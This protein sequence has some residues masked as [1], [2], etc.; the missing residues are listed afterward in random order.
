M[1]VSIELDFTATSLPIHLLEIK[2]SLD[3]ELGCRRT[4]FSLDVTKLCDG[5]KIFNLLDVK[6]NLDPPVVRGKQTLLLWSNQATSLTEDLIETGNDQEILILI[7]LLRF[8]SWIQ[9]AILSKEN[10]S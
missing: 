6:F 4:F 3:Q 10:L 8:I 7:L 9:L 5:I 1:P 2:Y